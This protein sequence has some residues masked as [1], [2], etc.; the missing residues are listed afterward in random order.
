MKAAVKH[1]D[2][3]RDRLAD[4]QFAASYLQ[5]ALDD[6]DQGVLLLALRRIADARGGM[7]K[8]AQ[9]TGLSREALYRTLS[10]SGNPRLATLAAILAATGLRLTIA[11]AKPLR[12]GTRRAVATARA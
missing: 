1:D 9:A 4:A 5:E 10:A 7:A 2:F 8:L 6:G 11:P 3:M 12:R